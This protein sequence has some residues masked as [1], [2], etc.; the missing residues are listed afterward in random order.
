ML[1]QVNFQKVDYNFDNSIQNARINLGQWGSKL[2]ERFF[3]KTYV[4]HFWETT[5]QMINYKIKVEKI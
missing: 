4:V 2:T 1:V 5:V 3:I